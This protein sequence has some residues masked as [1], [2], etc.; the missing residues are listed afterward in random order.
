MVWFCISEDGKGPLIFL[1]KKQRKGTDYVNNVLAGPLWDFYT[2]LV[3]EKGIVKVVEDGAPRHRSKA[4]KEFCD[5]YFL[6]TLLSCTI[7]R[8]KS[9]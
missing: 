7:S 1:D 5:S 4:A 8:H 9:Y 6:D 2:E 3:E